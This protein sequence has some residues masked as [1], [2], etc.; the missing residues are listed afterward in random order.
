MRG[1]VG[2]KKRTRS[3]LLDAVRTDRWKS[4]TEVWLWMVDHD[5][6]VSR[7]TIERHMRKHRKAGLVKRRRVAEQV[8]PII[9][10]PWRLREPEFLRVQ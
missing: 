3:M 6:K 4:L 1:E 10:D 5:R 7:T 8:S 9:D 2:G